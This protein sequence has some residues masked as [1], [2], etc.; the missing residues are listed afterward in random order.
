MLQAL[1]SGSLLLFFCDPLARAQQP[2]SSI[3]TAWLGLGSLLLHRLGETPDIV[4]DIKNV[5]QR[6]GEVASNGSGG[7]D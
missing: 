5:V 4:V 2:P 6:S 7:I 3:S 1:L